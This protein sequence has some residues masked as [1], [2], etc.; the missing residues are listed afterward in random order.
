[1]S[2]S[3]PNW[4]INH[5]DRGR[6][7]E[8]WAVFQSG[9]GEHA[10]CTSY[11]AA[12]AVLRLFGGVSGLQAYEKYMVGLVGPAEFKFRQGRGPQIDR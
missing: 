6:P 12:E 11:A 9:Y 3:R 10:S 2:L 1:M 4:H 7:T 8:C 5:Y